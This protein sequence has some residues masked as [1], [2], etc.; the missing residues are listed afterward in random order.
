MLRHRFIDRD[1]ANTVVLDMNTL[2]TG[3]AA[4]IGS[5][6]TDGF[7]QFMERMANKYMRMWIPLVVVVNSKIHNHA[8]VHEGCLAVIA[9]QFLWKCDDDASRGSRISV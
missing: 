8:A 2:D 1:E 6:H 7:N 9:D 4:L 3:S 5:S